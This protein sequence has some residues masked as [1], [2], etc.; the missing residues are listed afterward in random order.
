MQI[1]AGT[2]RRQPARSKVANAETGALL[3]ASQAESRKAKVERF[4]VSCTALTHLCSTSS[5][6]PIRHAWCLGVMVTSLLLQPDATDLAGVRSRR[7]RTK[8]G[9][10]LAL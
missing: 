5:S 1:V 4:A 2:R 8:R 6:D 3:T 7:P 10:Y 9:W